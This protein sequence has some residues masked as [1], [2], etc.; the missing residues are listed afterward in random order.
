MKSFNSLILLVLFSLI[1]CTGT[2][3]QE[4]AYQNNIA[5]T[6]HKNRKHLNFLADG[7]YL[8]VK[9]IIQ[10]IPSFHPVM[11]SI[12]GIWQKATQLTNLLDSLKSSLLGQSGY[13]TEQDTQQLHQPNLLGRPK[14]LASTTALKQLLQDQPDWQKVPKELTAYKRTTQNTFLQLW[15]DFFRSNYTNDTAMPD[16]LLL[17]ERPL[18]ILPND[19]L[20]K[21]LTEQYLST[22]LLDI[23]IIQTQLVAD[24]LFLWGVILKELQRLRFYHRYKYSQKYDIAVYKQHNKIKLGETYT[25]RVF[26]IEYYSPDI[27]TTTITVNGKL[28]RVNQDS[29]GF[30]IT[31]QPK[32]LGEYDLN[33]ELETLN[34]LTGEKIKLSRKHYRHHVIPK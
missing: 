15:Q 12:D 8:A 2:T 3:K 18:T 9:E 17:Q 20:T 32:A 13:Y 7:R 11:D 29:N 23:G 31:I 1:S 28:A 6:L 30:D 21:T 22:V 26:P 4:I 33:F 24:K 10:T 16:I 14:N 19:W 25:A 5:R 27:N 34:P